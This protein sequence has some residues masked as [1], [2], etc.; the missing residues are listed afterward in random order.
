M[1]LDARSKGLGFRVLFCLLRFNLRKKHRAVRILHMEL[2]VCRNVDC[3]PK[4]DLN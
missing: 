2:P 3:G 1:A 4:Y